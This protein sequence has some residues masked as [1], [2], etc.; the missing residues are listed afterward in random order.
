M[1]SYSI[2]SESPN[3]L[4]S[5]NAPRVHDTNWATLYPELIYEILTY[6]FSDATLSVCT[7]ETFP[8]YLGHI[9]RSWRSV[10]ISSPRFWDRFS[11][12][13]LP[14]TATIS[15][16]ER[17]LALVQLCIEHTK[18]HPFSFSFAAMMFAM[19]V[20]QS[21]YAIQILETL[22]A[23]AERW[24]AACFIADLGES[25]NKGKG[26]FGQLHTL[27]ICIPLGVSRHH[28]ASDLFEDAPNLT[29]VY[30][31][32]YHRLCWS[33][34]TVLHIQLAPRSAHKFFA[35]LEQMTSLEELAV[36]G[37]SLRHDVATVPVELPSLKTFSVEHYFPLS[38]IEAPSLEKL[39][40]ANALLGADTQ[41]VKTFLR[42][43]NHLNT[44]SFD[45]VHSV[46]IAT[47]IDCTPELDHLILAGQISSL[48]V[49][50]SLASRSLKKI[51]V[52]VRTPNPTSSSS[53]SIMHQL[54]NMVESWEKRQF[55]KLRFLSVYVN[56]RG[57]ED[58]SSAVGD[59]IRVGTDKGLE[60]DIS[61]RPFPMVVQFSD[62]SD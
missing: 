60:V 44:L 25:L 15:R 59:L 11:F 43:V 8:W 4:Q 62:W 10:F 52:G 48:D 29:R 39:Y 51:N 24:R 5:E 61:S 26:R 28:I 55:P 54:T 1:H 56:N 40:L 33:S 9:T 19:K 50:R 7:P 21:L 6:C 45:V 32:D 37:L 16:L 34:V 30:A 13:A 53:V 57:G 58:I 27:Q 22:V 36:R 49:L 31:T 2:S 46:D 35:E 18:D 17:A 38:L 23:H 20:P 47:I 42:G 12:H 41:I 3:K 14:K